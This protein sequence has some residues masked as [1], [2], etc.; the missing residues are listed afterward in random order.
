MNDGPLTPQELE[1]RRFPIGRFA[2]PGTPLDPDARDRAIA[3]IAGAPGVIRDAVAGL[4]DRQLDTPYRPEGWTVRQVV[5]HV[6]DSHINSYVRFK[7]AA[8]EDLPTI[9]TYEEGEWGKL[10]DARTFDVEV[11]LGLLDA[12]H[13]RWTAWLRTLTEGEWARELLHPES[14][15]MNLDQLLALYA[16]HGRHHAG[17]I[18]GLRERMGW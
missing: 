11:S 8:T 2:V 18:T 6:A 13:A 16:W 9:G 4:D 15:R 10:A 3:A 12:L 7:L 14:G 17:H 1:T 5:H